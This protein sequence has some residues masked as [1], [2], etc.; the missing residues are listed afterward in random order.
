VEQKAVLHE[1]PTPKKASALRVFFDGGCPLCRREIEFYRRLKPLQRFE[2]VD[3]DRERHRLDDYDVDYAR[4]MAR[5]HVQTPDGALH[6]GA[7]A[8]LTMWRGLPGWRRLAWL[9]DKGRLA[10]LLDRAYGWFAI[11]RLRRRCEPGRCGG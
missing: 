2:W 7:Y 6:T 11:R 4:A 3:I 9:L 8:F 1:P 10:P 5:L